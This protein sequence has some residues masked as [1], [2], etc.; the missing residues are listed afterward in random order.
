MPPAGS[1]LGRGQMPINGDSAGG[2][3]FHSQETYGGLDRHG[4]GLGGCVCRVGEGQHLWIR[5]DDALNF[6]QALG[7]DGQLDQ[8]DDRAGSRDIDLV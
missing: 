5:D 8:L 7:I 3:E 1:I 6:C 4:V 2:A